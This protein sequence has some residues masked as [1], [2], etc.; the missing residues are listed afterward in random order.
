MCDGGAWMYLHFD[1]SRDSLPYFDDFELPI[2][3][4]DDFES[5]LSS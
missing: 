1:W 4:L 3:D 5:Y 2:T